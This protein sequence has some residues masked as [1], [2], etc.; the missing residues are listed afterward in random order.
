FS[1]SSWLDEKLHFHLLKLTHTEDER[2]RYNFVSEGFSCLGNSKRN[3]HTARF[4]NIQEV[5]KNSLSGFWSQIKIGSIF[6]RSAQLGTKHQ[7]ELFYICPILASR[8]RA[9]DFKLFN[10]GF[11]IS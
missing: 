11:Y 2:S 10:Q 3:L 1:L 5:Y 6:C 9:H 4:L 8:N 7:I